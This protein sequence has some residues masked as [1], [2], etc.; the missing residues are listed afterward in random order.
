MRISHF[1]G[2]RAGRIWDAPPIKCAGRGPPLQPGGLPDGSRGSGRRPDPRSWAVRVC[3]PE[4]GA[5]NT[6]AWSRPPAGIPPGCKTQAG[7][8]PGVSLRSTPGYLLS[9]LRDEPGGPELRL[10]GLPRWRQGPDAPARAFL[11]A[12]ALLRSRERT[13]MS[14]LPGT[15]EASRPAR[16][17]GGGENKPLSSTQN[18]F[19]LSRLT[20]QAH[21]WT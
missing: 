13:R 1:S 9:S 18:L 14:A 11:S 12:L 21:V 17:R 3:T 10:A 5:R 15:P 19:N 20:E 7:T 16:W 4:R 6:Y 8:E 2:T